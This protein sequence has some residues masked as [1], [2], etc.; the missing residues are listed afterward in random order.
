MVNWRQP[1]R[2]G[3]SGP[4]VTG[5]CAG[6]SPIGGMPRTYG[7]DVSAADAVATVHAVFAGPLNFLDTSNAYGAGESERRIGRAIRERGGLPAGFVLD[8]KVDADPVSGDFSG[9]RVRRSVA[10][11]FER[12]GISSCPLLYLHDPEYHL[13]FKE[14][15]QPGG[16]VEALVQLRDEGVVGSIGVA[17]GLVPMLVEFVR[18]EVFAVV[19]NHNRFTLVDRSA[20]PLMDEAAKRGVGFVNGAPYGGGML[21]KGPAAQPRYCYGET[22]E[23]VREAVR[24]MQ[25]ACARHGVPLAA[26]ALQ[27]SLRDPRVAA[28]VVGLSQPQRI[29]ETAALADHAIPDELWPALRALTPPAWLAPS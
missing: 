28:T 21:V 23:F 20:E 16:P 5:I 10:E 22:P 15:M 29:A 2:L 17:A 1:R 26:A 19:L 18:T 12:L 3:K 6:G 7:Y 11:S 14:A 13:S 9:E 27:F 24:A 25:A 4:T 8:T